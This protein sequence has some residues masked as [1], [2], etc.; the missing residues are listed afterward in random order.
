MEYHMSYHYRKNNHFGPL[1]K[2]H[3]R[4]ITRRGSKDFHEN[5][6]HNAFAFV[7]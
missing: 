5:G 1:L 4:A 7:Y 6:K 2:L 3:A